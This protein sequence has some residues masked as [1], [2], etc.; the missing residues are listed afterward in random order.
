VS[1]FDFSLIIAVG[2][3]LQKAMPSLKKTNK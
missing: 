3:L 1:A 2:L